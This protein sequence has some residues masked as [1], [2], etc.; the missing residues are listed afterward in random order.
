MKKA[1]SIFLFCVLAVSVVWA[2]DNLL[3]SFTA[4]AGA[5]SITLEWRT[6]DESGLTRF[7]VERANK[8]SSYLKIA[9]E[10]AKGYSSTYKF[11]DSDILMKPAGNPDKFQDAPQSKNNYSYR[12]KAVYSNGSV[13]YSDEVEVSRTINSVRRTWGMIKEMFR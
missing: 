2:A 13:S 11:I 6:S 10:Q 9:D 12:L 3:L 4:N 7:E 5:N 1:I 8:N